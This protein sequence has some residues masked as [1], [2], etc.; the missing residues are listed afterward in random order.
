MP[1][2]NAP[3]PD[4]ADL[5]SFSSAKASGVIRAYK[6]KQPLYKRIEAVLLYKT[7][8]AVALKELRLL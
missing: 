4:G 6:N 7:L 5:T 1:S 2:L 3:N 8:T